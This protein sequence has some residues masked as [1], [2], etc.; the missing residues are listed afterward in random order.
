ME[1]IGLGIAKALSSD[2]RWGGVSNWQEYL[3]GTDPNNAFDCFAFQNDFGV[4]EQ[5]AILA[6]AGGGGGTSM[7]D[8]DGRAWGGWASGWWPLDNAVFGECLWTD[9]EPR[10]ARP[11]LPE[12]KKRL[13]DVNVEGCSEWSLMNN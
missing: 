9:T 12:S 5:P 7:G 11:V 10:K 2:D 4:M 8:D 13:K 3:T 6:L 1:A